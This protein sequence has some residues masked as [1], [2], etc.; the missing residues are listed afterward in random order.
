MPNKT[1]IIA[2]INKAYVEANGNEYPSMFDLFLEGFWAGDEIRPLVDHLLV[3]AMD[4]TALERCKFRRLNCYGVAAVDGGEKV[5]MTEEFIEMMWRRTGF[6][7]DVLNRG[8]D[9]I[10]TVCLLLHNNLFPF[11]FFFWRFSL[12]FY[13]TLMLAYHVINLQRKL[14]HGEIREFIYFYKI[15]LDHI[16]YI[17]LSIIEKLCSKSKFILY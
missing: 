2:I 12:L 5:Y 13:T 3:V 6:L 4:E 1:V 11:F 14:N 10:F 7:L 16:N 9:F 17:K 15:G 8:F